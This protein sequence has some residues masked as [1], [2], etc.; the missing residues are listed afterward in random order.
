MNL[1]QRIARE[2]VAI[3]GVLLGLYGVSVAFDWIEFTDAQFGA[4]T[5]LGGAL[6]FAIRWITTPAAE[7]VVQQPPNEPAVAGPAADVPNGTPVHVTP[8]A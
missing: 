1:M 8:V 5:T 2:P 4:I 3:A 7:V 6:V